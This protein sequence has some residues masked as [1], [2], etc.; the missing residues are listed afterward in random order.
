MGDEEKPLMELYWHLSD[1]EKKFLLEAMAAVEEKPSLVKGEPVVSEAPPSPAATGAAQ[2]LITPQRFIMQEQPKLSVYSGITGGDT[3]FG[4]WKH[5][6][7]CL[8]AEHTE[9]VVLGA[10]RRSLR[11]PAADILMHVDQRASVSTIIRKLDAIYGMVC[12]GQTILQRFYSD[13]QSTSERVAEWACRLEDLAYKA[14]EKEMMTRE[15]APNILKTQFWSGLRDPRLKDAL[16][17]R[18]HNL[19][20]DELIVE[21][22]ELEE[23]YSSEVMT[24]Q[25]ATAQQQQKQP[26]EME[27][28]MQLIKKMDARMDKMESMIA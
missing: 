25:T 17:H 13:S 1:A 21:A 12:T 24:S 15:A 14:V 9:S 20:V 19:D 8:M 6:V 26:T 16:W 23:E 11:S 4:R 22:R 3:S 18:R 10:I 5:E 7:T 27:L 28:L 2:S